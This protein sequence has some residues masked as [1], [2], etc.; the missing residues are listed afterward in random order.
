M[1]VYQNSNLKQSTLT[2][3]INGH[4]Y[5]QLSHGESTTFMGISHDTMGMHD[6][7]ELPSVFNTSTEI[8]KNKKEKKSCGKHNFTDK[9][10]SIKL[11]SP[12]KC[13]VIC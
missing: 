10:S 12:L 13:L 2:K 6:V 5:N 9:T 4:I 8:T 3:G 11:F 1:Y 7:A